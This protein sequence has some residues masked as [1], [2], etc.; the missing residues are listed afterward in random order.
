MFTIS[1]VHDIEYH[2]WSIVDI[3]LNMDLAG[4]FY[5][6]WVVYG[7]YFIGQS[8]FCVKTILD[9]VSTK[10]IYAT[11]GCKLYVGPLNHGLYFKTFIQLEPSHIMLEDRIT[12]HGT[13]LVA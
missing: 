13:H 2:E 9:Y 10:L 8:H 6:S 11:H 5:L 1:E 3:G 12:C 7:D 4:L